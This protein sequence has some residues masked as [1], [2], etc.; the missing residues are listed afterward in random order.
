MRL[1]LVVEGGRGGGGGW[2]EAKGRG[3]S[4]RERLNR[5]S[6]LSLVCGPRLMMTSF[7]FLPPLPVS[8][9]Q[10]SNGHL[11]NCERFLLSRRRANAKMPECCRECPGQL[12]GLLRAP[13]VTPVHDKAQV[14]PTRVLCSGAAHV[15]RL[16]SRFISRRDVRMPEASCGGFRQRASPI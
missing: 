4:L 3:D 6:K 2:D 11:S 10:A 16:K 8:E 5:K 1:L 9:G 14:S 15:S 12:F 13:G 7:C